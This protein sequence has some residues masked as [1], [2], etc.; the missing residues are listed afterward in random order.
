[1]CNGALI[2]PKISD[3]ENIEYLG[4]VKVIPLAKLKHPQMVQTNKLGRHPTHRLTPSV[5]VINK[6]SSNK[7]TKIPL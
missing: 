7:Q 1:M 2:N 3:L 5:S 4:Y 6:S